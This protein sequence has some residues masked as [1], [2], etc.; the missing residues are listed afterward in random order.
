MSV[1]V[2]VCE[3]VLVCS[4]HNDTEAAA[5]AWVHVFVCS[6]GCARYCLSS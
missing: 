3:R 4:Q 1:C 2:V 6:Q 5:A